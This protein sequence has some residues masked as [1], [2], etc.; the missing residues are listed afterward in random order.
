MST[1]TRDPCR[2]NAAESGLRREVAR[3][4]IAGL[5]FFLLC[6]VLGGCGAA[7]PYVRHA[8]LDALPLVDGQSDYNRGLLHGAL[9]RSLGDRPTIGLSAARISAITTLETRPL[10]PLLARRLARNAAHWLAYAHERGWLLLSDERSSCQDER[11]R[12]ATTT[13][14]AIVATRNLLERSTLDARPLEILRAAIARVSPA[15]R[16]DA[17]G[18]T[19]RIAVA[20]HLLELA[21]SPRVYLEGVPCLP[22]AA[23]AGPQPS[24]RPASDEDLFPRP[25]WVGVWPEEDVE[26]RPE[27]QSG[28]PEWDAAPWAAVGFRVTNGY[29]ATIGV[30]Y[31]KRL[32]GEWRVVSR[33]VL[34]HVN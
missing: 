28:D 11:C 18:G 30:Y 15:P 7:A 24:A 10:P 20:R 19:P 22:F 13:R 32:R 2:L 26:Y 34:M 12:L 33:E 27:F 16:C 3:V 8:H 14:D 17:D 31:L 21:P 9:I 23:V 1:S 5:S 4:R 29:W 25:M 6:V